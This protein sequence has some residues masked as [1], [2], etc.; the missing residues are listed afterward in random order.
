MV[1][2]YSYKYADFGVPFMGK[3]S[4][5][6]KEKKMSMMCGEVTGVGSTR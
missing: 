1:L 5:K 6:K 2:T 3:I 4:T